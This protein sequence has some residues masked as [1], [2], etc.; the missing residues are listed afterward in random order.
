MGNTQNSAR[1]AT[2]A[3][4]GRPAPHDVVAAVQTLVANRG[5]TQTASDLT[6][7]SRLLARAVANG[8]LL[9][10]SISLIRERLRELSESRATRTPNR[11]RHSLRL[12]TGEDA[13]L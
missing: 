4:K 7:D 13:Q 3:P 1:C 2:R 11:A 12:V 5:L 6:L 9:E 10:G 8:V